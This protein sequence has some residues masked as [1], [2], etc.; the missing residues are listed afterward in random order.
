MTVKNAYTVAPDEVEM[1]DKFLF[2]VKLMVGHYERNGK[3]VYRM[4]RCPWEGDENDL[5]QGDQVDMT[6][7]VDKAL[8]PTIAA[9]CERD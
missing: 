6:K 7:R 5:P 8:F 3:P 9:A 2:I 1:G 4:Y